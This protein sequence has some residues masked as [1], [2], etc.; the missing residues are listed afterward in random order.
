MHQQQHK[1]L[2]IEDDSSYKSLILGHLDRAGFDVNEA[3]DGEEGLELTRSFQ[4]DFVLCEWTLPRLDGLGYCKTVKGDPDLRGTYVA[5][6]SAQ[7]DCEDRVVGLEAGADDFLVKPIE[8]RELLAR[9]RAGLRIR[10]LQ[11]ELAEARHR[12]AL[13]DMVT[14]FGQKINDP[15]TALLGHMELVQQYV[16]RGDRDQMVRHVR[17]AAQMAYRI[18]EV[19]RGLVSIT[20]P[21]EDPATGS[22]SSRRT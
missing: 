19:A 2:L 8:Q 15:L 16:Q 5:M 10:E 1:V 20:G 4:P 9:V 11:S 18:A 12:V 14:R 22:G 6:Q 17:E 13:L 21:V 3:G 7:A